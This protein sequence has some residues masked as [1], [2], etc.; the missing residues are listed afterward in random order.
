MVLKNIGAATANI[1]P[2]PPQYQFSSFR[3]LCCI[4]L[5]LRSLRSKRSK[6]AGPPVASWFEA[7][8]ALLTMR[9]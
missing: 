6:D 2:S 3:S 7:R 9:D 5:I 1:G 8:Y 4:I